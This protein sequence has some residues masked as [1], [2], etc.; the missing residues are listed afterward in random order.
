MYQRA[1][2]GLLAATAISMPIG[3]QTTWYVDD[4]NCPGPGDGSELDP[5]CSIQTAIDNAV[6]TDEIVVAP[7]TYVEKINFIGKAVT[8]SSSDGPDVTIIDAQQMGS[9]VTCDSGEGSDTALEGFTITGGENEIGAGMR[10]VGSSP[11]VANCTFFNNWAQR[12]GG[13][14][15]GNSNPVVVGC[16]FFVNHAAWWNPECSGGGMY[17]ADSNPT[18]TG[19]WFLWNEALDDGGG[20]YNDSSNPVVTG[21]IFAHNFAPWPNS[22]SNGGG[23]YNADSNPTVA[24]CTFI[25]NDVLD[26]GG[27]MYNDNSNP[28]VANCILWGDTPNEISGNGTPIVSNSDVQGGWPGPGNIDADPLFAD[29]DGRLSPRSPCIDAGDNTAVPEGCTTDLDGKPRFVFGTRLIRFA[30]APIV[31]MGAYEFQSN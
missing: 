25:W 20:M 30:A 16:T 1:I 19:C 4:D 14:Y 29:A 21:C 28:T 10:I 3:G 23:M 24:C 7:G 22:E 27:G 18:V 17:N 31:D 15:S 12:G 8:L 6:D 11:R 26:D 2:V 5:F 9:A 13:I